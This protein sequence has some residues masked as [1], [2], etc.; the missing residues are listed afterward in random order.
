MSRKS[1][2]IVAMVGLLAGPMAAEEAPAPAETFERVLLSDTQAAELVNILRPFQESLGTIKDPVA[3][4][5]MGFAPPVAGEPGPGALPEEVW[6]VDDPELVEQTLQAL[7][8]SPDPAAYV[9][10]VNDIELSTA[11][12]DK[13]LTFLNEV[14]DG[15][16]DGFADT[17]VS[18]TN[19]TGYVVLH[20]RSSSHNVRLTLG[21]YA[22]SL[23]P[24]GLDTSNPPLVGS[25][26]TGSLGESPPSPPPA[27]PEPATML[28]LLACVPMALR[29]RSP[30]R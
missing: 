17:F 5:A 7:R 10:G 30:G 21:Q 13:V 9:F 4:G 27:V 18:D 22:V 8:P 25:S 20:F 16:K 26:S 19:P 23:S 1:V 2:W 3:A 15:D 24:N 12:A 6:Q 14:Q 29:R 28:L 11:D